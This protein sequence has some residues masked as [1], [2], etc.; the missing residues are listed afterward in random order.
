MRIRNRLVGL[1]MG[2]LA[3]GAAVAAYPSGAS[4]GGRQEPPAEQAVGKPIGDPTCAAAKRLA[5][6]SLKVIGR[7]LDASQK[8]EYSAA[9]DRAVQAACNGTLTCE[10]VQDVVGDLR[11]IRAGL[12]PPNLESKIQALEDGIIRLLCSS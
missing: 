11:A 2:V 10:L 8:A 4:A 3:L 7:Y 9:L 12:L 5:A 6:T 1:L